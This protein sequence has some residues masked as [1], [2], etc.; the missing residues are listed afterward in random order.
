MGFYK[1]LGE[2]E[3]S[4]SPSI[5]IGSKLVYR[6][7][8]NLIF[9]FLSKYI[10]DQYLSNIG[11]ELSKLDSYF[12]NDLSVNYLIKPKSFFKEIQ[13][14]LLVNNLFNKLYSSNGYW[15]N[16][17]DTWSNPGQVKTI[18]GIGLYPQATTNYLLGVRIK[19]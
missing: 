9:E 2:T 8:E 19:M 13:I 4:F 12:I 7:S 15:Y 14:S 3:I 17:D 10:G 16:Y 1:N 18:E 11:S 5:I 6:N